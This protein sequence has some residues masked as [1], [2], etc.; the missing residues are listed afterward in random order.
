MARDLPDLSHLVHP[1]A[2]IAVRATPKAARN[3]IEL[4]GEEIRAYVTVA[5]EAG[6]AN[7]ALRAL[8]AKALG[9]AKS[10]LRLIRGETSRDKIFEVD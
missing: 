4:R 1:G 8:L 7:A 9:I 3:R 6:K 5:P 2:Q 10:R